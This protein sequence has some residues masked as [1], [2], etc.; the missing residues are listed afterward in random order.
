MGYI[1]TPQVASLR[2]GFEMEK[3]A[4][5]AFRELESPK[6]ADFNV[7]ECG[8]VVA[9]NT[10]FIGASPDGIVSC[11]CCAQSVLEIKCPA[12]MKAYFVVFTG[13]SLTTEVIA[14]D[15]SFWA[16]AKVKAEH[17]FFSNIF[18]E[19]QS[20]RIFK[21]IERAKE[22]CHCNGSKSGNI[23]ECSFCQATFHLKCVKLRRTPRQWACA[24]CQ[25]IGC[26]DDK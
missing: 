22:T 26:T 13:S 9:G 3:K 18:P 11:A 20:M 24:N 16:H 14:F 25:G 23:V 17:F 21:Q 19:L 6:H 1:K 12:S 4:K 5:Q 8:L 2:R 10:P 7:R 15:E